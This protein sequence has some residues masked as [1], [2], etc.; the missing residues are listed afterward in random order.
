MIK[1][2]HTSADVESDARPPDVRYERHRRGK[3]PPSPLHL[4]KSRSEDTLEDALLVILFHET[5]SR[6]SMQSASSEIQHTAPSAQPSF[7]SDTQ[8]PEL[9]ARYYRLRKPRTP[10][11]RC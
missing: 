1:C 7:D 9:I 2:P 5:N 11:Y 6:M 4:D 10:R 8:H 3:V